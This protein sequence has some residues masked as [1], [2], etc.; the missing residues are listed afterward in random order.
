M[1]YLYFNFENFIVG[2][3]AEKLLKLKLQE[4]SSAGA[5]FFKYRSSN[6]TGDL[7]SL[8]FQNGPVE[9]GL[10]RF[11]Q[12]LPRKRVFLKLRHICYVLRLGVLQFFF[13]IRGGLRYQTALRAYQRWNL[14]NLC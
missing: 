11:E 1:N 7:N 4:T 5:N 8:T 9:G 10:V 14:V 3:V 2:R 13:S 6:F 12:M